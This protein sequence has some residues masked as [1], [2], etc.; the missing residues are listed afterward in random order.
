MKKTI[1]LALIS[2]SSLFAQD[3]TFFKGKITNPT[4]KKCFIYAYKADEKTGRLKEVQIDSSVVDAEGKFAMAFEVK[5]PIEAFFYDGNEQTTVILEKGDDIYLTLNTKMFDETIV[6]SG[7]GA[8][9]NNALKNIALI[10]ES[11]SMH[12]YEL[13][14]KNDTALLFT[15]LRKSHTE[16]KSLLEDYKKE[17]PAMGSYVDSEYKG[18][19]ERFEDV[20]QRLLF[21]SKMLALK[22]KP[23]IDFEG[24][25]LKGNKTKISAFK[26]KVTV[27]DFWATWCGPCRAE[28]PSFKELEEK[29]GT[30]VNFVSVGLYCEKKDWEKMATG[31]GLKNNLFIAKEAEKQLAEYQ[32]NFIPRYIVVDENLNIIDALAPRPSSGELQRFFK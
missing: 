23:L 31:F 15:Y 8:E 10:Q 4:T 3:N 9:K 13:E 17:L 6:Y 29:Y 24:I 26:G 12:S 25:D 5:E 20:K 27:I 11:I 18:M 22:G 21:N 2:C 7:K 19:D 28:V 16:L 30:T 14:Q 32:I 1:A